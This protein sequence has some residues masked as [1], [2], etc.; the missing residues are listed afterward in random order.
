MTREETEAKKK[1][2]YD[3][4]SEKEYVPMSVKEMAMVL[5]VPAAEK[6]DLRRVIEALAEEG[7]LHLTQKGKV[8]PLADNLLQGRY[9]AT[10]KGFGFVRHIVPS[11]PWMEILCGL[12]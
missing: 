9:M 2:V 4:I 11:M 3:F 5:Q 10:Q 7:K 8:Q 6:K 12:R 1:L